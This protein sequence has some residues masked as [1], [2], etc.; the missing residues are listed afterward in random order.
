MRKHWTALTWALGLV[1]LL[2]L[3]LRAALDRLSANPVED[4]THVTGEW[5]LRF[6]ILTLAVTPARR[7]LGWHA[8]APQRR[9]LGLL[10]FLYASAHFLTYLSLDLGFDFAFLVEDVL[11]RPY[12]TVGFTSLCL[13]VP[14]ALTSTRASIRRLGARWLQLHRLVYPAAILGVLHFAWLVK[15]DLR[16]PILHGVLLSALLGLRF[17]KRRAR[18]PAR[19][20]A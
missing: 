7:F 4:I 12:I 6:L 10:A 5:A 8:L 17:V 9:T 14:L 3:V 18:V 13:M 19:S 20:A 11:E 1:P 15:A 16:S 2:V